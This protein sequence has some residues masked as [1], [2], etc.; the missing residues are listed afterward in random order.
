MCEVHP[1]K[2]RRGNWKYLELKISNIQYDNQAWK[3]SNL[4]FNFAF[5]KFSLTNAALHN[6]PNLEQKVFWT[7]FE[8][9]LNATLMNQ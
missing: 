5:F 1:I 3:D 4:I 9:S 8:R 7:Q 2:V 6:L